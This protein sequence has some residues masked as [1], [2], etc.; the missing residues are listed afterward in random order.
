MDPTRSEAE[1]RRLKRD[2]ET[3]MAMAELYCRGHRHMRTPG[4]RLCPECAETVQYAQARTHACP[5]KH[6][7]TC[8]T[9]SIQCYK[10]EM[11][12]RIRT[13]MAYSGPRMML[14]HPIMAIRHLAK[15]RKA[16][17]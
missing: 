5:H 7:G 17:R 15:K 14:H 12:Q 6:Q 1:L 16:T 3:V 8:D 2:D 13:I 10:P 4:Q 11:R 9:C